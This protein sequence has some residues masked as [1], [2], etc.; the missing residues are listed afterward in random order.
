MP[1]INLHKKVR[2]ILSHLAPLPI[3]ADSPI[4]HFSLTG[5]DIGRTL[6]YMEQN[7]GLSPSD[8]TIAGRHLG[9]LRQMALVSII[10]N[11]ER[12]LKELAAVCK[13]LAAVCIDVLAPVTVDDRLD[14]FRVNGS[15]IAGHFGSDTL[16][17]ALCEAGTWL[18]CKTVNDRYKKLLSDAS[19]TPPILPDF[20]LFPD[21][22]VDERGR[23]DTLELVW[24]LRHTV[25]HNVGVITQSDAVK[26]R[27]LS[28]RTIQSLQ[29]LMP[30]RIDI[31]YLIRFLGETAQWCNQRVGMRLAEILSRI[32]IEDPTLF[33]P[34]E[35][36]AHLAKAFQLQITVA[37]VM[38]TPTP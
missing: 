11:L 28:K 10:E 17:R 30:I 12:F 5:G 14:T 7:T 6:N 37:G 26:L 9:R 27:V 16:G 33:D 35:R 21:K 25:V 1:P 24:Q 34:A 4:Q 31:E 32:H 18:D 15:A 38:Q 29:I 23:R 36:A 3:G 20:I 13:E 8:P 22:P 2:D 19:P